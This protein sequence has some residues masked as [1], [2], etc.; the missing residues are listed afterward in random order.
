[1]LV[2]T[3]DLVIAGWR[4][5]AATRGRTV[6]DTEIVE[7]MFGRRTVDVLA[8]V[9]AIPADEI[10]TLIAGG[11]ADKRAEVAA[12]PPLREI[13]GA[14][15]FVRASREAGIRCAVASSASR[16]NIGLAL[17]AIGLAG[18]FEVIV[19]AA[20]VGRGKPAP[21][22]YL[23]AARGLGAEPGDCVVFE[24]T[25]PGIEAGSAAGARCVGV[26]TLGRPDLLAAAD[27][28]IDDFTAW[29]PRRLLEAL[30][31]AG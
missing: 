11:L 13:P 4:T 16:D 10:A 24:D 6:T 20:G 7:R 17:D 15:A 1:V 23:V 3:R 8:D 9:F 25:A 14:A 26:A 2:E 22:P 12:G 18:V 27:M 28:V 21:D 31:R 5:F 19:D 30:A 29:T